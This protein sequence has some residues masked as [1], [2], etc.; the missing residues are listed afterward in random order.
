VPAVVEKLTDT[1]GSGLPFTSITTAVI[2]DVPPWVGTSVGLA[3]M[4]TR[5]TPA[6]P[7]RILI[8]FVPLADTPPERAVMVAVP[9]APPAMYFTMTRPAMSVSASDG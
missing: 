5:P 1:L 7:M 2:T 4:L 6:E 3:P 8:A 9:E